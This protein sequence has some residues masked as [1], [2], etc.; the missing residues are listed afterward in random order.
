MHMQNAPFVMFLVGLLFVFGLN[1]V[2]VFELSF[3]VKS[4]GPSEG[5]WASFS[6]GALITL[7]STPCSAPVL[8]AATA[9]AL[10]KDAAW[11]ETLLLFWSIGLG[12]SL[13]VLAVG[14]IPGAIKLI[15]RPGEQ[16]NTFK[17]LV[18]ITLLPGD[19]V[20]RRAAQLSVTASNDFLV[21]LCQPSRCGSL[22][23]I[24]NQRR[25][26]ASDGIWARSRGLRR[27][28]LRLEPPEG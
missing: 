9:A 7:V 25:R 10:G 22:K 13:P 5:L 8:G 26:W 3:A 21:L 6:H 2:G 20:F 27:V 1:A 18:G 28:G 23:M 16:T 11:Y 19:R 15:P 14:F 12:L 24:G 17:L 4:S